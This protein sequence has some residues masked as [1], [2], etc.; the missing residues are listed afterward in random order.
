[1]KEGIRNFIQGVQLLDALIGLIGV[2]MILGG[3]LVIQIFYHEAPCPLCLL[4]RVAFVA[5]GIS[6]LM[7]LRYGNRAQNWASAILAA[8]AGMAVSIRQICLH[9][10]SS[11]G[12]GR[13][14]WG[15]HMYTWCFIAFA[16]VI[17]GSAF[18]LLI[19]PERL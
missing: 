11:V 7:N 18:M 14:V 15:L 6:F 19:Y 16:A 2:V 8:C 12:F 1:M 10:T 9:I 13:A 3:A 4:Q 17:I 5:V